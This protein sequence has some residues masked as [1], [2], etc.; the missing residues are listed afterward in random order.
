MAEEEFLRRKEQAVIKDL[1]S[2]FAGYHRLVTQ[3]NSV[4][5]WSVSVMAAAIGFLLTRSTHTPEAVLATAI[6]ALVA[7]MVL[8]LRERSSMHFNKLEVL[9]IQTIFMVRDQAR[10]QKQIE[11]YQFRDLRLAK[12]SRQDK[13][14]HLLR[15]LMS[16]QVFVWY[17]FWLL[18]LFAAYFFANYMVMPRPISDCTGC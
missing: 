3:V 6:G 9:A 8:E 7:F 12:L 17:G 11:E 2:A 10:Y 14:V 15:S 1:E 13:V 18:A 16:W 5:T 4:R